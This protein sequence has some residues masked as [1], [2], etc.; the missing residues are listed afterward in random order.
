MEKFIIDV[1]THQKE[2]DWLKAKNQGVRRCYI[3]N[4]LYRLGKFRKL[5][6]MLTL[7]EIIKV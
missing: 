3:K 4:W 1:S 6:S 2:I 7:K 5:I